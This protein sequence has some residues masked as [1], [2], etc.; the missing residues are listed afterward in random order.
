M[1]TAP[2]PSGDTKLCLQCSLSI[3][4]EARLCHHCNAYQDWRGYVSV[5]STVLALILA[6]MSV[7]S[8]IVP[9]M[10]KW[11]ANDASDIVVTSPVARGETVYLVASNLGSKPGVIRD[12][13]LFSRYLKGPVELTVQNPADAFLTPGSKQVALNA[14]VKLSVMDARM[15]GLDA[16]VERLAPAGK[17]SGYLEVTAIQSNE[18]LATF[19]LP[20]SNDMVFTLLNAHAARCEETRKPSYENGCWGIEEVGQ[21]SDR[22]AREVEGKLLGKP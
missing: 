3:P 9:P 6:I 4:K 10:V 5:S 22:L 8:F 20:V 16:V 1:A 12:G 15:A 7:G 21:N 2:A 13:V 18:K 14:N 17:N 11:F 19:K